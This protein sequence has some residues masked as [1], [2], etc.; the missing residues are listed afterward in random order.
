MRETLEAHQVAQ[1]P[2][3]AAPLR[4]LRRTLQGSIGLPTC[5]SHSLCLHLHTSPCSSLQAELEAR[6]KAKGQ[7]VLCE[8]G[9]EHD[10]CCG[11]SKGEVEEGEV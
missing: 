7:K 8:H 4:A 9:H 3:Q 5:R 11:A 10:V 6:A 1:G 2:W